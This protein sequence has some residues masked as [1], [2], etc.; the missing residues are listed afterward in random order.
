QP[1]AFNTYDG[2]FRWYSFA[3]HGSNNEQ[4]I[5]EQ[6]TGGCLNVSEPTLKAMLAS[7]QLGDQVEVKTDGPCTP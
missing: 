6:V 3:I 7:V 5:G 1:F 4:R 2:K